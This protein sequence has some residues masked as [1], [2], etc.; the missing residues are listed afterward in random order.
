MFA[1][2]IVT[3]GALGVAAGIA[4]YIEAGR[5]WKRDQ[6]DEGEVVPLHSIDLSP[7]KTRIEEVERS[8]A[9]VRA[10]GCDIGAEDIQ[11]DA[12]PPERWIKIDD[13]PWPDRH[14]RLYR[15]LPWFVRR[16][17]VNHYTEV[18]W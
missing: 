13:R 8:T 3:I 17:I 14:P 5:Q 6:L 4:S 15:A 18:D 9:A 10:G 11:P 2:F 1:F 7:L 12:T 16:L